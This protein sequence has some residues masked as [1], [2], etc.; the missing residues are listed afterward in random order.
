[1][2]ASIKAADQE[3]T[4]RAAALIAYND[5]NLKLM[6]SAGVPMAMD[7][8]I[9][10]RRLQEQYCA[11]IARCHSLTLPKQQ[12]TMVFDMDFD[13]CLRDEAMEKYELS[14]SKSN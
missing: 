1:M 11:G 8:I 2:A 5:A 6:A 14:P 9:A 4:C 12:S 3:S 10:Q 7:A 13:N